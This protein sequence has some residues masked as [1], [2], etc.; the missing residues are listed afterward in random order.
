MEVLRRWLDPKAGDVLFT[1][2]CRRLRE[3]LI[4]KETRLAEFIEALRV[5]ITRSDKLSKEQG[6][7]LA[8]QLAAV[9]FEW[10]DRKNGFQFLIEVAGTG[11]TPWVRAAAAQSLR[12]L[13]PLS[14]EET[15]AVQQLREREQDE[16]VIPVL[17]IV[18]TPLK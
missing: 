5:A 3:S 14:A 10:T 9:R 18:L 11:K 8:E 2:G 12:G 15:K 7:V 16:S 13:R 17:D 4:W 1:L 6:R